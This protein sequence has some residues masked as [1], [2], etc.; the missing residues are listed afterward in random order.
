ML[1]FLSLFSFLLS[2]SGNERALNRREGKGRKGKKRKAGKE[3]KAGIIDEELKRW[4]VGI[5]GTTWLDAQLR[6]RI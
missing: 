4:E 5:L 2:S 1:A 3:E 6:S